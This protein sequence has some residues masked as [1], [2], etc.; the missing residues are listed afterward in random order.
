MA[1]GIKMTAA[2]ETA[3]IAAQAHEEMRAN[4]IKAFLALFDHFGPIEK[5]LAEAETHHPVECHDPL[6]MSGHLKRVVETE[7]AK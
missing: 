4:R 3:M 5:A 7:L 1:G 6:W 2:E